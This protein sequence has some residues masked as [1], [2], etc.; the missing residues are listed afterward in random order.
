MSHTEIAPSLTVFKEDL[1]LAE[2][3]KGGLNPKILYRYV[4]ESQKPK[5]DLKQS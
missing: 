3:W 5:N 1:S 2:S 4:E